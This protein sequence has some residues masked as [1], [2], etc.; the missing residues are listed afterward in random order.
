MIIKTDVVV[1]GSGGA[2][3]RAAIA[4]ADCGVDVILL[5]QKKIDKSGA[6]S[7]PVAEMAGYNAGDVRIEKDVQRH[8]ED[9]IN[10]G[11][12]MAI[13]ELASIL[14]TKAPSTIKE[15][16]NWGV[17]FE[18]KDGDYYIFKSCFASK[19][20]THVIRGHGSQIIK[21]MYDK[22][23][24]TDN[25]RCIE[26]FKAVDLIINDGEC[27]GVYGVHSDEKIIINAKSVILA[28]GG[29]GQIFENN[30]NP[31]DVIGSG[32]S[33]A[34]N[35]GAKLINMEFM[36]IGIGFSKP[37]TNIF[38]SYIWEGM[39]VLSD[40][41]GD[42]IFEGLLP[43][44]LSKEDVLHEHRKH[45][46][47]STSDN[48]YYLEFA[49]QKAI[50]ENRGT[51][52]NGININLS[53]M[54]EEY[55]KN[56]KD[57]CGIHHMWPIAY[58]YMKSK[59]VDLLNDKIEVS[60]FAHA[61]NGGISIDESAQSTIPGLFAAGECA[62]GPHGADRLGGNMMVT[63]QVFGKIAGE[64]A[65]AR[66]ISKHQTNLNNSSVNYNILHKKIDCIKII[67]ELKKLS[68][69]NLLVGRTER[70]LSEICEFI[71]SCYNDAESAEETAVSNS[72]NIDVYHML[73]SAYLIA[74]S[75]INRKETRGSHHRLD[76][77]EK[78][79]DLSFPQIIDK[80]KLNL[81]K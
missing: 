81:P 36:Q 17:E 26:G 37:I 34:F 74:R 69:K 23:I 38:N 4:A 79:N 18:K 20:R 40:K 72:Q 65:A 24:K 1:V 57:D 50:R 80:T 62:G 13:P 15:L 75:A 49:I 19:P 5:S 28:T 78:N 35:A 66:A 45:F 56:L 14:A 58:E 8:Y 31:N 63:C 73:N 22:I 42:D 48:S 32:Y 30:M 61:I 52:N 70:G 3:M 67:S 43:K 9:I 54:T 44:G 33:M 46:P 53:N 59:G 27:C 68:Q 12:G 64:S 10:A 77:P 6:T 71:K 55:V 60:C 47:F 76:F 16:E 25:I 7:Y 51:K 11:Q 29:C 2:G 39:P 41:N 21:A